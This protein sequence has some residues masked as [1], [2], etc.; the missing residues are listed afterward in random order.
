M[1]TEDNVGDTITWKI[2]AE[3]I[4]PFKIPSELTLV[5]VFSFD[6]KETWMDEDE[7]RKYFLKLEK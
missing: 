5:T 1:V 6:D 2:T 7:Y 3:E 4:A